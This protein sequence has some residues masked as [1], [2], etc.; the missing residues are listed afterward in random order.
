MNWDTAPQE[1][2]SLRAQVA[3]LTN[4]RDRWRED[5]M[6]QAATINRMSAAA[7]DRDEVDQLRHAEHEK[8]LAAAQAHIA[9]LRESLLVVCGPV[10]ESYAGPTRLREFSEALAIPTNTA[11]LGAADVPHTGR[12]EK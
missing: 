5:S 2:E 9:Q 10:M 6:R 1:L 4:E 7:E 12:Q 8:E 11:A 3:A